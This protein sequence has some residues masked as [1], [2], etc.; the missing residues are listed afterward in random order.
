LWRFDVVNE[1]F[2]QLAD[3][4]VRIGWG[5]SFG[6]SGDRLFAVR[7]DNTQTFMQYTISTNTW[8]TLTDTPSSIESRPSQNS[9]VYPGGDYVYLHRGG[10]S[11]TFW[12]YNITTASWF[13]LA[14]TIGFYE[15]NLYY[16][17]SDNYIYAVYRGR[18]FR[19]SIIDNSWTELARVPPQ[20]GGVSLFYPG[21]G[22]ILYAI[23]S[24]TDVMRYSISQDTWD[25][26]VSLPY[27]PNHGS[28]M[29]A[30]NDGETLFYRPGDSRNYFYRYSVSD[31][32]WTQ[33]ANSPTN[34]DEW[35]ASMT[36]DGKS[37]VYATRGRYR[38]NFWRYSVARNTWEVLASPPAD[39]RTGHD[40]AY[41]DGFVYAIRGEST[42]F[43]RY[44]PS[45]DSW[46]VMADVPGRVGWGGML[47]AGNRNYLYCLRGNGSSDFY[48]YDIASN[49]WA[50]LT[51]LSRPVGWGGYGGKAICYPGFGDYIYVIPGS[52]YGDWYG[53]SKGFFR[54]SISQDA[55]EEIESTPA[56]ARGTNA[57]VYPGEGSYM[58][59]YRGGYDSFEFW[60]YLA[61]IYGTYTSEIKE[62]GNN[63]GFNT[64]TWA[65]NGDA[66]VK[67]R[68]SNYPD[69]SDAMDWDDCPGIT[70]G[71]D[72]SNYV[73]VVD[74]HRY[75][76]Y[77]VKLICYDLSNLPAL[78]SIAITYEYYP[79]KQSLISNPY[80]S[81]Y[82]NNRI[83]GLSWLETQPAGTDIRFQLRT[84]PDLTTLETAPWL[85][86]GGIQTFNDDYSTATDYT[87][88]PEI[89]VVDGVA[90]L[91]KIYEEFAYTQRIV[92]DNSEGETSYT[93]TVVIIEITSSNKD[94]WEHVKSDGSDVRFCDEEGNFLSY[95]LHANNATFDYNNKY[96]K[97]FVKVPSIP[98]GQKS[99][100][101]LKYGKADAVSA[102][103]E[104]VVGS[105]PQNGLVGYWKFDEGSGTSAYDSSGQGNNGT[106]VNG[107]SWVDGKIGDAL[108]FDGSNDYVSTPLNIDQSGSS[109]GVTM[110]AWVYPTSTS[111]GRHEMISSDN[112]GYDW[113]L[114]REGGTWYVF[115]GE[116]TRST[117]FS[118][119][120]NQW[121]H[122]VAVFIPGTGVKFYKNGQE[123]TISYIS[124]DT[125][126]G[127][128]R[129]GCRSGGGEY[130]G[131]IIDEVAIYKR[132]LS[133][134]EIQLLYHCIYEIDIPY[135]FYTLEEEAASPSLSGWNKRLTVRI[136]NSLG[137]KLT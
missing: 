46:T 65:I 95:N 23:C 40:I 35:S 19:Y 73:S 99:T 98:A 69:M 33:D 101:Y 13:N 119:D 118:V 39:F 83:M 21:S 18:F 53:E 85:G 59:G 134:S 127:N 66:E 125:S 126:D 34:V 58:Y 75:L 120:L 48:R 68:T 90:R 94:F 114:L 104:T 17:G 11:G 77:Q 32:V 80:N 55:W 133:D 89:E 81:T 121:Q 43:W 135:F 24:R 109:Q 60:K 2:T 122:V 15:T 76:Q 117:G 93:D 37:Y 25:Q 22:D 87:Y 136:D 56:P 3:A 97:I 123:T 10:G 28:D 52:V 64:I 8:Q 57:L 113:S 12:A 16:P 4:P 111:S 9:L 41:K 107:P 6:G 132:V 47:V 31:C 137:S 71:D 86:P 115:T 106:L 102:S 105:I 50:T 20:S 45:A 92:L 100:I 131:G 108:K 74:G 130:F 84:G 91:K 26:P 36:T 70:K 82:A 112:G 38:T 96:A 128:I 110:V 29:V 61:F 62:I 124:Y 27:R 1:T 129:I 63:A 72:L 116:N 54:Y 51:S 30:L 49:S 67:V 7:G 78:D 88:A 103:D 44:N 5:A 42:T 79:H 14:G